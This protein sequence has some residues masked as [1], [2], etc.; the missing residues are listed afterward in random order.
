MG[1]YLGKK[2]VVATE[3]LSDKKDKE[4]SPKLKKIKKFLEELSK[5]KKSNNCQK[6]AAALELKFRGKSREVTPTFSPFDRC[7]DVPKGKASPLANWCLIKN[8]EFRSIDSENPVDKV[9][10]IMTKFGEGSRAIIAVSWKSG[11]GHVF[12]L[13]VVD[14]EVYLMDATA[15]RLKKVDDS[16]Y[17]RDKTDGK[18]SLGIF[19]T[20]NGTIDDEMVEDTFDES[21]KKFYLVRE[22]GARI[23]SIAQR[24]IL[25]YLRLC[26]KKNTKFKVYGDKLYGE[27]MCLDEQET[28]GKDVVW[29]YKWL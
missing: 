14:G 1:I 17:L 3:S 27:I 24:S 5:F 23:R 20:D 10:E 26:G 16:D 13:T 25:A 2:R 9:K 29:N 15:N 19:R 4:E 28:Y 11:R 6:F 18:K 21:D 22:D 8:G 12:N 7:F